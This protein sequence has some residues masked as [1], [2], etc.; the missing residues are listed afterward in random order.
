MAVKKIFLVSNAHIDPV[1]QWNL[2]EGKAAAL[3]TFRCAAEFCQ[4]N[5]GYIFNHNEALLYRWVEELDPPLFSRIQSLVKQGKWRIIGGFEL[6]PDCVI[7]SGESYLRQIIRGQRYF[8]EKFGVK[9][10]EAVNFDSFGHSRG[11]VQILKKCG[12]R[13]Y[14]FMRPEAHKTELPKDFIWVG[15]D[16]SEVMAHRLTT[17]YNSLLGAN[18]AELEGWIACRNL[19][20]AELYTWGVGD[21]G[22]GPSQ[23]D[24]EDIAALKE[25]NPYPNL[26]LI[27]SSIREY[28]DEVERLYQARIW[29]QKYVAKSLYS[30]NVGCYTSMAEIKKAH[31]KLENELIKA[32]KTAALLELNGMWE[33]PA[34][35]LDSAWK[36]LSFLQ[37]HDIL[38]GTI[39]Q[40][41]ME[42][43]LEKFGKALDMAQEITSKGLLALSAYEAKAKDGEIPILVYNPHPYPIQEVIECEFILQN[44]NW[45][46]NT[47][48]LA[49][50]FQNG[51]E[52][53][54]QMT[55]EDSSIPLDWRK[56]VA[57][58]AELSPFSITRFDCQLQTVAKTAD[59]CLE[60]F[61]FDNGEISCVI[62]PKTG[63]MDQ[64][65][66]N[67][68]RIAS[69][70]FG[71]IC[72]FDDDEDPW[73]MRS[74]RID[75]YL[76][77]LTRSE[78]IPVRIVEDGPVRMIVETVFAV[79]GVSA[80]VRYHLPKKGREIKLEITLT[81]T[82][83]DKMFK[84]KLP[85]S[86]PEA[87]CVGETMFL[88]EPEFHDGREVVSHKFDRVSM[89]RGNVG[90]INDGV[91]GGSFLQGT[92]YKNLLRSPAFCA[93]PIENRSILSEKQWIPRMGI[94]RYHYSFLICPEK[95]GEPLY[96]LTQRAQAFNEKPEAVSCFPAGYRRAPF[97]RPVLSGQVLLSAF[98]KSE[99]GHGWI[100]RIYEPEGNAAEFSVQIG[101]NEVAGCL[102]P[103]EVRTYRYDQHSF[104][105][106]NLLEQPL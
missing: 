43:M 17:S 50:V 77:P 101:S 34:E 40:P 29:N 28:F 45:D 72:V 92:L 56:K 46:A 1:W 100:L 70:G 31:R 95:P 12:Y 102:S 8:S 15:A 90:I 5:P 81:N 16:G 103:F 78:E 18:R 98:K 79:S 80:L 66:L 13:A 97:V 65:C 7:P 83:P 14:L 9:V 62:N 84:I 36:E 39:T 58:S 54:S 85:F 76:Y 61:R 63:L 82:L 33:Y 69:D 51:N 19:E 32:E 68:V 104:E 2:T 35:Q 60:D 21:H 11:I 64:F 49:R 44:Q 10:T 4:K 23:K 73:H 75:Q 24:I 41:V 42:T 89:E 52:I 53:P 22:G 87:V 3:A 93:H 105:E 96:K 20:E 25:E 55:K 30:S 27:H 57:F 47:Q 59:A 91:Y 106:C 88:V 94:G 67:G 99:D 86:D 38:P 37:F 26:E 48:T 74:D 6:Q 71:Q